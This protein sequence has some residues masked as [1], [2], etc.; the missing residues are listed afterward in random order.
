MDRNP[1]RSRTP[2]I[3]L[4]LSIIKSNSHGIKLADS[5]VNYLIKPIISFE[6]K[7]F[8]LNYLFNAYKLCFGDTYIF[9]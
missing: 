5:V 9:I 8:K 1:F 4:S 2:T 7:L 3:M 6:V